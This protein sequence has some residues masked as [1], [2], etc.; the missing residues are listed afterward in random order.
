[1]QK[2]VFKNKTISRIRSK[3]CDDGILIQLLFSTLETESS[4][5]KVK[6]RMM[7]KCP[8]TEQQYY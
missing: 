1:M 6:N 5:W 4:L 2:E 7:D 3:V 8:K